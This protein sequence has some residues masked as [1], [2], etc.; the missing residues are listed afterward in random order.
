[1]KIRVFPRLRLAFGLLHA[2]RG[3]AN[4]KHTVELE[5]QERAN[6]CLKEEASKKH[7]PKW[8]EIFRKMAI[9]ASSAMGSARTFI[10]A[11]LLI[12]GWLAVGPIFHYSETWQLVINTLT[13]II[14]FLMVF[15][16]QNT[17]NRD[18]KT[19][20]LKLDEL[21]RALEPARTQLVNLELQPDEKLE[22][23][24]EEFKEI[25]EHVEN[26]GEALQQ[27]G[28]TLKTSAE[29]IEQAGKNYPRV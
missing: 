4:M 19:M 7:K 15:L 21:I 29:T 1:M 8:N 16:I 10:L 2:W 18:I 9:L 11:C 20:Q 17:Q 28:K 22:E 12:L 27:T 3:A 13:T 6:N 23:I 25:G 24:S 14:T 5:F 26:T